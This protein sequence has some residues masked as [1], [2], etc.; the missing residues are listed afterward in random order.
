MWS[1]P[2]FLCLGTFEVSIKF[3]LTSRYLD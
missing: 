2:L 3:L 1:W